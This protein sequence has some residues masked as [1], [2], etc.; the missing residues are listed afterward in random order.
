MPSMIV[1]QKLIPALKKVMFTATAVFA[2][3]QCSEDEEFLTPA[4]PADAAIE[5]TST[6]ASALSVSSLTVTGVNTAFA[7]LKDCKTCT[8]VIAADE[9]LIDGQAMG[10]K[11][12]N[13]ICLNKGIEYGNLEFINLEGSVENPIIIATIGEIKNKVSDAGTPSDPY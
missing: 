11:P 10:I 2:L 9:Q 6:D 8:Y 13:I 5:A 4:V 3:M 1:S 12:G 7:T